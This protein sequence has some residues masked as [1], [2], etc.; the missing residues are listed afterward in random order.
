[1]VSV[2]GPR[3]DPISTPKQDPDTV[4]RIESIMRWAGS[5]RLRP[6]E[7]LLLMPQHLSKTANKGADRNRNGGLEGPASIRDVGSFAPEDPPHFAAL[8]QE[9]EALG[10]VVWALVG[11][12]GGTSPASTTA[13]TTTLRGLPLSIGLHQKRVGGDRVR[14]V[15]YVMKA[16]RE[17]DLAKSSL[18]PQFIPHSQV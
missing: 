14:L 4:S 17:R 12:E 16:S 10:F 7:V 9:A 1:M 13:S 8:I 5:H 11:G 18:V 2:N 3:E 15:G 6:E